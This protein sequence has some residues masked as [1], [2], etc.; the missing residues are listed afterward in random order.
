MKL[1]QI[2]DSFFTE[3]RTKVKEEKK[4]GCRVYKYREE[5][6]LDPHTVVAQPSL[7]LLKSYILT[8]HP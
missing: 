5:Q 3:Q 2:F 4:K 1:L 7:I 6:E 8:E